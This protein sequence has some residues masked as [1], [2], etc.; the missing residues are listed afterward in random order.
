[1]YI[2]IPVK[3]TY[4]WLTLANLVP[5]TRVCVPR[6]TYSSICVSTYIGYARYPGIRLCMVNLVPSSLTLGIYI[7]IC[8]YAANSLSYYVTL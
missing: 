1:M 7:C 4:A 3:Y 2:C 5:Y 6:D 8:V